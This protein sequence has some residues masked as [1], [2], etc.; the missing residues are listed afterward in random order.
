MDEQDAPPDR[1]GEAMRASLPPQ[2]ALET[3]TGSGKCK[4]A[5][6]GMGCV[7]A[8]HPAAVAARRVA[9]SIGRRSGA[10]EALRGPVAQWLEP[11]AHNRLVAG[12]NPAGPTIFNNLCGPSPA[13]LE[14]CCR[15]GNVAVPF[16][17]TDR[18]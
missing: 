10:I 7:I 18:T 2:D 14:D 13:D 4:R 17:E 1:R 12:S 6:V 15:V 5:A 8:I 16:G 3:I 11:A 9:R